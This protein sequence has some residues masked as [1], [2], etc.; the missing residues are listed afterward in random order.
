MWGG[1]AYL[2]WWVQNAPVPVPANFSDPFGIELL[3]TSTEL[4]YTLLLSWLERTQVTDPT[5]P[6]LLNKCIAQERLIE[7]EQRPKWS[8]CSLFLGSVLGVL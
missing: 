4:G 1:A 6:M 5:L 2:L 8:H 3:R 7:T